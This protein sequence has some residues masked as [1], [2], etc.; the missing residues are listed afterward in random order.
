MK[1]SI[2]INQKAGSVD[3]ILIEKKVRTA[4]F[5]CDLHFCKPQDLAEMAT[6]IHQQIDAGTDY[7][8]ICGGDGTINTCL[9][10]L[11]KRN[12][13]L[14]KI[15]PL[16]II[17]SGTANDL[18]HE[19]GVSKK[20]D[21]AVRGVLEGKIKNIDV[22]EISS[23]EQK[24]YMVTNGGFGIPAKTADLAN[25]V[26]F[27]L[28][29]LGTNSSSFWLK[30]A[31]ESAYRIVKKSGSK[32]YSLMAAE[33]IRS[34]ENEGW[35]L[36]LEIPGQNLIR[37]KAPIVLVNNQAT[38]GQ[39][40]HPAPFTSNSDGTVNLLLSE[41]FT[42]QDQLKAFRNITKGNV[43]KSP[44]F[45]SYEL[46]EFVLRS[47]NPL[48]LLTF[49]GDGEIL[50]RDVEEVRIRCLHKELPVVVTI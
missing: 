16:A 15:P 4:L 45:K 13:D 30:I 28:R 32:I 26:R 39:S 9:Q 40:F 14:N 48:R 36:E 42:R 41:A 31:A 46:K 12:G 29:K 5:R 10:I 23:G 18:A 19:M 38:I 35:D 43:Q 25:Q 17:R 34:W 50:L 6:F 7:L 21:V 44:I 8:M 1:I 22:I 24:T 33:A 2:I 11:M 3:P 47:K 49:F 20:I 27:G 37:T